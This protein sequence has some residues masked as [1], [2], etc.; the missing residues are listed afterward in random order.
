MDID[1]CEVDMTENPTA[2]ED[3]DGIVLFADCDTDDDI[4]QRRQDWVE[5]FGV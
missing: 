2:D 1:G 4:E 5:L 3:I